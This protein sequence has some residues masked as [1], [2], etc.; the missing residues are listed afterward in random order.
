[1]PTVQDVLAVKAREVDHS[2]PLAAI[3]R[4]QMR[5]RLRRVER[6]FRVAARRG[7]VLGERDQ[8]RADTARLPYRLDRKLP[9]ASDIV[10]PV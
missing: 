7:P 8:Q 3:E 10:A 9:Q 6:E 1:M 2:K 4:D 5:R